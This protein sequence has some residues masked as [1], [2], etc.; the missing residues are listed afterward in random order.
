[1]LEAGAAAAADD[2]QPAA[3]GK[4]PQHLG[5]LGRSLV[6]AAEGVRQAGVGVAGDEDRREARQLLDVRAH[7][8]R[9]ESAV[10]ADG[11]ERRVRDR[12]PARLHGL[13][14][15]RASGG[16]GDRQRG[17]D[18]QGDAAVVEVLL[19]GEERRLEVQRVEGGFG[20]EDVHAAVDQA[21]GLLVV[22]VDQLVER[23]PAEAGVVHVGRE[24][25]RAVGR[26]HRAGH[27]ARLAG[28]G[29]V[30]GRLAAD[31]CGRF[32]DLVH[33]RLQVVVGERDRL[34]VEGVGLDDVRAGLEVLAMHVV[35]HGGVGDRQHVARALEIARMVREA[36]AA[37]RCLVQP[38]GLDLRAHRAVEDE[39]AA[40]EE[41]AKLCTAVRLC[42]RKS[43]G[44]TK[45]PAIS[46][47]PLGKQK[48]VE[49]R[50]L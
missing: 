10:D 42:H 50:R 26:S 12:V 18:R 46:A 31:L 1:V 6:V 24:R 8:F 20:Q 30:V 41:V 11:E 32:V 47:G 29:E 43:P 17:D 37:E 9:A 19:D 36:L 40:G 33:V 27:E 49:C 13:A 28:S 2:V 15:E 5:H 21:A 38:V 3:G 44:K 35:E 7:L 48:R 16:V 14:A 39:D 34:R 23:N 22:R 4:V 25:R 45:S